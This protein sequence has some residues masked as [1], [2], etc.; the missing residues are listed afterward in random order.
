[1]PDSTAATSRSAGAHPPSEGAKGAVYAFWQ[2]TPCGAVHAQASAGSAEFFEQIER[3]R[4]ELEPFIPRYA[5]FA[6]AAGEAVLEIGVG[7][8]SDFARFVRAGARATGVDLTDHAVELVR[9]RLSLEGLSAEVHR[10]D[11]ERLPF[12]DGSF[13]RVYSWG[14]LH[15]TPDV[16]RAFGEAIRVLRPGGRL[17]VMVYARRSWVAFGLWLRYALLRGRPWLTFADVIAGHME[18]TG[19]RAFT[20]NELRRAFGQLRGLSVERVGTP[21]DA[22]VA[23]PLARLTGSRLGWFL[24]VQGVKSGTRGVWGDASC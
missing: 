17:C 18:S 3:R 14:V 2:R 13:D 11:A 21:Y 22:R 20:S 7:V 23:G 1:M 12:A 16:E 5:D 10:A 6:G 19:T 24:V 8:G 15:H 9:G 4:Y